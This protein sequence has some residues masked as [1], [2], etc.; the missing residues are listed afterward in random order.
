MVPGV[1]N[2]CCV[3]SLICRQKYCY[4]VRVDAIFIV[5]LKLSSFLLCS[6]GISLASN[7]MPAIGLPVAS[8]SAVFWMG[9]II[10]IMLG[11][12]ELYTIDPWSNLLLTSAW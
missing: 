3:G 12:A 1:L 5:H 2:F 11:L 8:L 7:S 6:R 4:L 10:M 9:S